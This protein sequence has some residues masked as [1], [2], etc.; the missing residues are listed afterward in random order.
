M[1]ALLK[2]TLKNAAANKRRSAALMVCMAV[3]G[4]CAMFTFSVRVLIEDTLH[5]MFTET[6]GDSQIIVENTFSEKAELDLPEDTETFYISIGFIEVGTRS[7]DNF[8][9]PTR[10]KFPFEGMDI[11]AAQEKGL[12]RCDDI[13]LAENEILITKQM[14]AQM[15]YEV[16]STIEIAAPD[17]TPIALTVAGVMEN[18]GHFRMRGACAA[19]DFELVNRVMGKDTWDSCYVKTN[20]DI[21]RTLA[22]IE[23]HNEFEAQNLYDGIKESLREMTLLFTGI[24]IVIALIMLFVASGMS[25]HIV[26]ERMAQLGTLRSIGAARSSTTFM[27]ISENLFYGLVGA[28]VGILVY[29]PLGKPMIYIFVSTNMEMNYDIHASSVLITLAVTSALACLSAVRAV[30]RAVKTPIRDIIFGSANTAYTLSKAKTAAGA[31]LIVAGAVCGFFSGNAIVVIAGVAAF[32]A[33]LALVMPALTAAVCGLFNKCKRPVTRLAFKNIHTKK[34]VVGS[35]MLYAAV[36]GL[37]CAMTALAAE[38]AS[39]VTIDENE[40]DVIV[41]ELSRKTDE[42][43]FVAELD[44]VSE[45]EL[46][47]KHTD[48][49]SI[50][51]GRSISDVP[52]IGYDKPFS[53]YRGING[54]PERIEKG[55]VSLDRNLMKKYS[56]SEGDTVTLTL[57]A[58]GRRPATLTLTAL[59]GCD[60]TAAGYGSRNGMV[61]NIEDFKR[62]Y[63]DYPATLLIDLEDRESADVTAEKLKTL[64]MDKSALILTAEEYTK[65]N[66]DDNGVIAILYLISATGCILM[67]ILLSTNQS[68][69]FEQ[70]RRELAVLNSTA[71]SR[72][73]LKKMLFFETAYSL[74][75]SSAAAFAAGEALYVMIMRFVNITADVE[76]SIT[77]YFAQPAVFL[78]LLYLAALLTVGGSAKKLNKMNTAAQIKYE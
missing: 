72:A 10:R 46:V 35:V 8:I 3:V 47:Y 37:V 49:V 2:L 53:I 26:R 52:I 32:T 75:I 30:I 33:G 55:T 65:L 31:A 11:E 69:G 28:A 57:N 45:T 48:Q 66:G 43:R 12:I 63:Y 15:G 59:S 24:F 20:G 56:I 25:E 51:G 67:L 1:R 23:E 70:R 76:Q 50:N 13:T 58:K 41:L 64:M 68:I 38:T 74:L 34:M 27:L 7:A 36:A 17:E 19:A 77:I 78:V 5:A 18:A 73:Q 16:G 14:A 42:Y 40:G 9:Y 22:Y 4:F 44:G 21:E 62:V 39:S 6:F 61:L 60:S 54:L 71:M 29:I